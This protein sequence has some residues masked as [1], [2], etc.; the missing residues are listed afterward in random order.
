MRKP[1]RYSCSSLK[2]LKQINQKKSKTRENYYN[3]YIGLENT[4]YQISL[5]FNREK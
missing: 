2:P 3:I 5:F 1:S 4:K